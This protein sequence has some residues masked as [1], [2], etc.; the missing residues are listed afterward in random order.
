M[1]KWLF[2]ALALA[3]VVVS[4]GCASMVVAYGS[5]SRINQRNA[6]RAVNMN[7]TPAVA[8]DLFSMEAL[9]ERPLLQLGAAIVD[10]IILGY[11]VPK[12]IDELEDDDKPA[13]SPPRIQVDV[14]Q[15]ANSRL[16]L[17][18]GDWSGYHEG[19]GFNT[20]GE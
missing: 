11:G 16:N 6:I 4:S 9:T 14:Q 3:L 5:A 15:G 8:V 12:A 10:A 1:K 7:G 2:S 13:K 19:Q 17:Q 18:T 20:F